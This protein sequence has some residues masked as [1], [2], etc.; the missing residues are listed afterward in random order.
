MVAEQ[1]VGLPQAEPFGWRNCVLNAPGAQGQE[2]LDV[3]LD[4][5]RHKCPSPYSGMG[6]LACADALSKTGGKW[7]VSAYLPGRGKY[8]GEM[9]VDPGASEDEFTTQIKLK[10]VKDGSMLTRSGHGLVYAGYSWRGRSKAT[11]APGTGPDD[12][13]KE[14]REA[15]WFSPDQLHAEGRWFWGE[16]QEFGI[17]VK[18]Q[19]TSAD[20]VLMGLD[21]SALKTGSQNVKVRLMGVNLR[22]PSRRR[23]LISE[24]AL[25]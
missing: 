21:R 11:T 24:R 5:L 4:F 2:P 9:N 16:Y 17:D 1:R 13:S 18:M 23:T 15:L 7:L 25:R 12:T 22:E 6:L 10:S 14:M 8:F 3:A 19:R 20:P